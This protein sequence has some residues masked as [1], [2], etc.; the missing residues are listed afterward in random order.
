MDSSLDFDDVI[1][2]RTADHDDIDFDIST[3]RDCPTTNL[4][5]EFHSSA[6]HSSEIPSIVITEPSS[7]NLI[8]LDDSEP[9]NQR[10][11]T[12]NAEDDQGDFSAEVTE[13]S[14]SVDNTNNLNDIDL[15][16]VQNDITTSQKLENDIAEVTDCRSEATGVDVSVKEVAEMCDYTD[17]EETVTAPKEKKEE[18]EASE[19]LTDLQLSVS[20]NMEE[21]VE[22]EVSSS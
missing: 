1:S 11:V 5:H 8:D 20:A 2:P 3:P 14:S 10:V 16:V 13:T 18:T 17:N 15:D 21:K 22:D 6:E 9:E 7:A 4:Q 12:E 19:K